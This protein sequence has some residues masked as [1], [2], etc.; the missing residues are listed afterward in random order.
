MRIPGVRERIIFSEPFADVTRAGQVY[1]ASIGSD[2]CAVKLINASVQ[3]S[4]RLFHPWRRETR[5][6]DRING[7]IR[8]PS[9][10]TRSDISIA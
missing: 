2:I 4:F 3:K 6:Y 1:E 8:V 5:V 9:W 7:Y 10:Q